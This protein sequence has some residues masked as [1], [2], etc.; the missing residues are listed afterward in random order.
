MP[1]NLGTHEYLVN[2]KVLTELEVFDIANEI[3]ECV[4]YVQLV[5]LA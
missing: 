4:G 2:Q 1:G 3:C 5:Q